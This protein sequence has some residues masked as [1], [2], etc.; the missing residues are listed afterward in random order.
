MASYPLTGLYYSSR[1]VVLN[2]YI[3]TRGIA[4]TA[5]LI[6]WPRTPYEYLVYTQ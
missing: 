4:I 1:C 2:I 6:V 3:R 5:V